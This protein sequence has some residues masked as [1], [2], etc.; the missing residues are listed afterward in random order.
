MA[1]NGNTETR[2]LVSAFFKGNNVDLDF[3]ENSA[4]RNARYCK[5]RLVTKIK[6]IMLVTVCLLALITLI[7][8]IIIANVYSDNLNAVKVELKAELKAEKELTMAKAVDE[9]L[10]FFEKAPELKAPFQHRLVE[11]FRAANGSGI[12][13]KENGKCLG[14]DASHGYVFSSI[15]E[16]VCSTTFSRFV[17]NRTIQVIR[18]PGLQEN[19]CIFSED[20][21]W[22]W[23]RGSPAVRHSQCS[24][25]QAFKDRISPVAPSVVA[26]D[27]YTGRLYFSIFN[28]DLPFQCAGMWS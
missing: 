7:S 20:P 22:N 13:T 19:E 5:A 27:L 25:E 21:K 10:F 2:G 3:E 1:Q 23:W 24:V 8:L 18:G 9:K 15:D 28:V 11:A 4:S 12:R 6:S 16:E 17:H 14:F 26:L